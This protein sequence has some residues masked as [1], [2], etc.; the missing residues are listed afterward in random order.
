MV[1]LVL[2]WTLWLKGRDRKLTLPR[3]Q[4][5]AR[6]VDKFG[7]TQNTPTHR[8]AMAR[9]ARKKFVILLK[10]GLLAMAHR[11]IVLPEIIKGNENTGIMWIFDNRLGIFFHIVNKIIF[12]V[13]LLEWPRRDHSN[14]YQRHILYRSIDMYPLLSKKNLRLLYC[15]RH[16]TRIVPFTCSINSKPKRSFVT[17]CLHTCTV[18]ILF[19]ALYSALWLAFSHDRAWNLVPPAMFRPRKFKF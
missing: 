19:V 10:R 4:F 18:P 11:T 16:L 17:T 5:G 2:Q 3:I 12:H 13:Y 14:E 6:Y 7:R 15:R 1:K 8:S 9:L